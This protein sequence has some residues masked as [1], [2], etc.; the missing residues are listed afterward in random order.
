METLTYS[1]TFHPL[2]QLALIRQTPNQAVGIKYKPDIVP[3]LTDFI[4]EER[5]TGVNRRF[6]SCDRTKHKG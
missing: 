4:M 6:K 5:S 3:G 1:C 2:T